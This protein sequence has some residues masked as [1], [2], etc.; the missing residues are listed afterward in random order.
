M[1]EPLDL[2]HPPK[3]PKDSVLGSIGL[4]LL[5]ALNNKQWK[6]QGKKLP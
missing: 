5:R 4:A 2:R 3:P 6:A 1:S